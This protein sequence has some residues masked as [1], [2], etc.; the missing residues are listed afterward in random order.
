MQLYDSIP[1]WLRAPRNST[2]LALAVVLIAVIA[3]AAPAQLPV[4][5]YKLALVAIA[6][7][8]GYWADRALFPYARPDG[9]LHRDW[10]YGGDGPDGEVDFP[11]VT[12]YGQ[13]FAAAM[14]RRAIV[15][16]A[17]VFAIALGL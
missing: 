12:G 13:V 7:V 14:V 1:V 5:L 6:L 10:R 8:F 9:Y 3:I 2:W 15:V 17:V 16:G 4:M 11:V